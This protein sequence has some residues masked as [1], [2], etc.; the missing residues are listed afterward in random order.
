MATEP[1]EPEPLQPEP[2]LGAQRQRDLLTLIR[3]TGV[4]HVSELT[5]TSGASAATIRRD[6]AELERRGLIERV[7]G[8][9][10]PALRD[11][12]I[13]LLRGLERAEEKERIGRAAARLVEPGTPILIMG[14]TTTEAM[15][16]FLADIPRLLV[17]T[18]SMGVANRLA[19]L[20]SA[21]V[22]VL[23]GVMRRDELSLLGDLT[24]RALEE[25]GVET[26]FSGAYGVDPQIGVT[27][28]HL[29]ESQTDRALLRSGRLVLLA[30]H[31]KLTQRGPARLI[32][33]DEI[34]T[35][36]TDRPLPEGFQGDSPAPT[37][38][39]A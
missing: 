27:G 3:S 31:S 1:T 16:P 5:R 7:H 35:L 9:A 33:F 4:T 32:P 10:M 21:D 19:D 2:V 18:N 6:L 38:V 30:D 12:P 37:V 26:V 22:V 25:F 23:G 29:V 20:P 14:G 36:V 28:M 39:V 11:E 17:L 13:R 34:D 15:V 24:L 8:G